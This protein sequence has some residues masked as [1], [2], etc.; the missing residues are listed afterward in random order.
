MVL[1][2]PDPVS[3][4]CGTFVSI[5]EFLIL[6]PFRSETE[7]DFQEIV[8]SLGTRLNN[9]TMRVKDIEGPD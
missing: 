7:V 9:T 8:P 2:I 4:P 5:M 6:E 1:I 3:D